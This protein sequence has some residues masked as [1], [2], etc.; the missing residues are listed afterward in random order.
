MLA[1]LSC[2]FLVQRVIKGWD[3]VVKGLK[4]G[5][6]RLLVVPPSLAYGD[7]GRVGI[8]AKST[9]E[10]EVQLLDVTKRGKK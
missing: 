7:K 6:E 4:V 1:R 5:G 2:N 9:L 3:K 10:F 8:S